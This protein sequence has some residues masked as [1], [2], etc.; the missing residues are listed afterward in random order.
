MEEERH[1]NEM[2]SS[3][4]SVRPRGVSSPIP[5]NPSPSSSRPLSP[6]GSLANSFSRDGT[7]ASRCYAC[8]QSIGLGPPSATQ[9]E[10]SSSGFLPRSVSPPVST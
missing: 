10:M 8:G 7:A 6:G 2:V 9:G 4:G 1:F 3:G 5:Y